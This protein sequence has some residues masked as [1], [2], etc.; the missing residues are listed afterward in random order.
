MSRALSAVYP[1]PVRSLPGFSGVRLSPRSLTCSHRLWQT[2]HGPDQL[3]T[4]DS[5]SSSASSVR[6]A[7][8]GDAPQTGWPG[9]RFAGE[10]DGDGGE[11][12][13]APLSFRTAERAGP[14]IQDEQVD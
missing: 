1:A 2:S 5:F 12:S 13:C 4:N 14:H 6:E 10:F 8:G 3:V 9:P 11:Q 7:R